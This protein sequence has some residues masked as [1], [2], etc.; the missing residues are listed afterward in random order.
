[1]NLISKV[2]AAIFSRTAFVAIASAITMATPAHARDANIVSPPAG[3]ALTPSFAEEFSGN[4]LNT[5]TWSTSYAPRTVTN[6]TIMR[7]NLYGNGEQEVY[8]DRNYLSLGINPFSVSNH[9]L[10]ITATP[11][12]KTAKAA[13][14]VDLA[15]NGG[16]N[17]NNSV[18]KNVVYSSGVISTRG[19][20][21]QQ[22]GYFEVRARW[23]IGKGLWPAF[24]LLP[25][26]GAW[27]PEIDAMEALGNQTS[28]IYQSSHSTHAPTL[29]SKAVAIPAAGNGQQFHRYG[30]LWQ[31]G[32]LD[33]Y[34][35]GIKTNTYATP[36]DMAQ[37]MY[38]IVNLAVG[39]YWPGN[40]DNTVKF[41]AQLQ[42]SY[43][44]AWKFTKLP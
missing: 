43:V 32:R 37:P 13:V 3:Y 15:K 9:M 40:P 4:A 12:S 38:M 42:V 6:A 35:D 29:Q 22:Y 25:A 28:K 18:L 23:S 44:R 33:Y 39:G 21:V 41:P 31:P 26:S 8:F 10:T 16:A 20:F 1:M 17:A 27:P 11:L 7:R 5:A 2:P 24:W 19:G 34:I 14:A 30:V 36:P